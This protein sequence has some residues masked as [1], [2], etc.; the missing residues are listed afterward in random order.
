MILQRQIKVTTSQV[1]KTSVTNFSLPDAYSRP[2]DRTRQTTDTSGFK[3]FENV[4]EFF[5]FGKG[6]EERGDLAFY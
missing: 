3:P 1:V 2:D 6:E 5:F 4:Y